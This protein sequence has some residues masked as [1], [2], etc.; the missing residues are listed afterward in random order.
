M[1]STARTCNQHTLRDHCMRAI[2]HC[3][4]RT[5]TDELYML[6]ISTFSDYT[7]P[8]QTSSP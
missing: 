5:N 8:H 3:M 1:A 7:I 2:G 6:A 4:I